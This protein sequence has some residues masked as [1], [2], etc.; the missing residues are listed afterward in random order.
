MEPQDHRWAVHDRESPDLAAA[1]IE[2][3]RVEAGDRDLRGW[4]L[5]SDN[6]GP[7]KGATMLATLQP[8]GGRVV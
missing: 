4:V 8:R 7:M 1:L 3:V 2:R 6:G 5:H